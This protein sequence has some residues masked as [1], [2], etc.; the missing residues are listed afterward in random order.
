MVTRSPLRASRPTS[1]QS[2]THIDT[3]CKEVADKDD[4]R[5][6]YDSRSDCGSDTLSRQ[7]TPDTSPQLDTTMFEVAPD[8]RV[9]VADVTSPSMFRHL[10]D[11]RITKLYSIFSTLMQERDLEYPRVSPKSLFSQVSGAGSPAGSPFTQTQNQTQNKRR[12][13]S[14]PEIQE[15]AMTHEPPNPRRGSVSSVIK[16][17]RLA[18]SC[19]STSGP[20]PRHEDGNI[21]AIGLASQAQSSQSG[22]SRVPSQSSSQH[23]AG[24][25][26]QDAVSMQISIDGRG[27]ASEPPPSS[28]RIPPI[29]LR[30]KNKWST[31]AA[32]LT[33]NGTNYTKAQNTSEGFRIHPATVTD[34]RKI[35]AHF[36]ERNYPYHTFELPDEKLL[37]VVL[38]SI[39]VEITTEEV[40]D[41]LVLQGFNPITVTRMKRTVKKIPMPLILVKLPR[42]E[43]QIYNITRV[44]FVTVTVEPLQTK[45][46]VGQCHRC[47]R[48]GHA[49]SR[50]TAERKCV[51]CG[52]P[53]E[54][55]SC[56]IPEGGELTCANCRGPHPASYRG[57]PKAPHLRPGPSSKSPSRLTRPRPGTKQRSTP[58]NSQAEGARPPATVLP[59]TGH[60]TDSDPQCS[61]EV[62]QHI[63]Q[64]SSGSRREQMRSVSWSQVVAGPRRRTPSSGNGRQE[65]RSAQKQKQQTPRTPT[66]SAQR[67]PPQ[68]H[69][70]ASSDSRARPNLQDVVAQLSNVMQQLVSL[71]ACKCHYNS[72]FN[73]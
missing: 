47:Q 32:Y 45:G 21:N 69:Q 41:D 54:P 59:S 31:A 64:T 46:P 22:T 58:R 37:R 36:Q 56:L 44:A 29:I 24:P 72:P 48:F 28:S 4:S 1:R 7:S 30:D 5:S 67:A 12:L 19:P 25:D 55:G 17:Q 33:R 65:T 42:S 27:G 14:S 60:V 57:C 6:S 23:R 63:T 11:D 34:Y 61:S 49:Q 3:P 71:A 38:R 73:G 62:S 16:R 70:R 20:A 66:W 26:S 39:P 13:D 18:A 68:S 50:C 52:E 43:T 15:Q 10:N 51:R 35:T 2:G 53:H 8:L 9:D 40:R